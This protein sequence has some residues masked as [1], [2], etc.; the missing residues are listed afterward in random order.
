MEIISLLFFAYSN[1]Y[2]N[3]HYLFLIKNINTIVADL[4]FPYAQW[5]RTY[6]NIYIYTLFPS[7]FRASLINI[8]A[9]SKWSA[10]SS[11]S[12]SSTGT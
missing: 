12:K 2:S 7:I 5:T 3:V 4:L 11:S 9:S 1:D 6:N 8:Y 10:I